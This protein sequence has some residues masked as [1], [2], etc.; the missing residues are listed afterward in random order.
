MKLLSFQM[1]SKTLRRPLYT[2]ECLKIARFLTKSIWTWK[3]LHYVRARSGAVPGFYQRGFDERG[4]PNP[5]WGYPGHPPP[6]II[7]I[8]SPW[9][10]DFCHSEA[11]LGYEFTAFKIDCF[12]F[13]F[14]QVFDVDCFNFIFLQ[15]FDVSCFNL[16][17]SIIIIILLFIQNISPILFG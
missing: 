15:V 12:N 4:P 7:E 10:R 2:F 8:S 13:V 11:W 5:P 3:N 1:S 17:V 6:E 9:K 16:G 14:L